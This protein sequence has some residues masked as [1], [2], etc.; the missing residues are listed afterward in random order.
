MLPIVSLDGYNAKATTVPPERKAL[1]EP[2]LTKAATFKIVKR[3]SEWLTGRLAVKMATMHYLPDSLTAQHQY[4]PHQ[5][6]V[7]NDDSGRPFLSGALPADLKRTEIS[8]SHGNEYA[9]AIIAD[10]PCGID[11]ES[12]RESLRKVR[13]KFCTSD[14]EETL[15]SQLGELKE[16]QQL[17]ILWTAKESI[18]K[19]LSHLHMPGF[20]DL[21]LT[22]MEPHMT[23][24]VLHF[25][26]SSRHFDKFPATISVVS[27]LYEGF[28]IS[29]CIMEK[30]NNA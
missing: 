11:I 15:L 6:L 28:G 4:E 1:N 23:G 26:I 3:Q 20:L 2:E 27:E 5:L 21:M 14:E 25:V 22:S 10:S 29:V 24:W 17:T 7:N 13:D 30:N 19:C 8:L 9:A 18:K 16:L 12:S